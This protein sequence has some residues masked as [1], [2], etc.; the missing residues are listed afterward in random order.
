LEL[1]LRQLQQDVCVP[2]VSLPIHP[3]VKQVVAKALEENRK[4]TAQD[5]ADKF[6]FSIVVTVVLLYYRIEDSN[7]LNQLQKG[8]TRWVREMQKVTRLDPDP[9]TGT[10]MQEISFWHNMDRALHALKVQRDSPEI[11][12]TLE[13]LKLGKRF[14]ATVGFELC[15]FVTMSSWLVVLTPILVS[16]KL[17]RL[18]TTT[19]FS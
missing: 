2:E 19:T 11:S 16:S 3:I 7:F 6:A 9:S 4:P 10:T 17:L 5:F 1:S 18:S 8:V 12:L 14:H 15:I 13:V